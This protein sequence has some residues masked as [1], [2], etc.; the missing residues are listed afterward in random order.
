M[1]PQLLSSIMLGTKGTAPQ[2]TACNKLK[3]VSSEKQIYSCFRTICLARIQRNEIQKVLCWNSR[4]PTKTMFTALRL[5]VMFINLKFL[6]T[7]NRYLIFCFK[8]CTDIIFWILLTSTQSTRLLCVTPKCPATT[9]GA[10]FPSAKWT[11]VLHIAAERPIEVLSHNLLWCRAW[12]M[13][14]N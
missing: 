14:S 9:I 10:C 13:E 2:L 11:H 1:L 3:R 12:I 6:S 7:W 5:T 4:S 8:I